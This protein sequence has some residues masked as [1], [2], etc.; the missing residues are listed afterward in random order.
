MKYRKFFVIHFIAIM[1]IAA[2]VTN[3]NIVYGTEV[4]N[5]ATAGVGGSYY[6]VGAAIAEIITK[7]VQ[8][9]IGSAEVTGASIENIKLLGRGKVRLAFVEPAFAAVPAYMGIED[10]DKKIDS[11]V[12]SA[13]HFSTGSPVVLKKSGIKKIED[14]KGKRIAVGKMGSMTSKATEYLLKAYGLSFDDIE[15]RYI[16]QSEAAEALGDGSVDCAILVGAPPAASIMSIAATHDIDILSGDEKFMEKMKSLR[17]GLGDYLI[18]KNTYKGVDH[19]SWVWMSG[20]VLLCRPDESSALIYNIVK[21]M[22]ENEEII[23]KSH[24]AAKVITLKNAFVD[25]GIPYH[26]GAIKYYNEHGVKEK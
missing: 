22:Y 9:A 15:P 8:G 10:F 24:P 23:A 21:A 3:S 5:I 17:P 26:D 4:I 25:F 19:N 6:P 1:L 20:L 13:L 2:G 7:H 11:R 12:V 18:P 14:L 16:G